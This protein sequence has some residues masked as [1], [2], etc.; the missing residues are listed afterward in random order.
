METVFVGAVAFGA[1][2]GATLTL[3]LQDPKPP[4]QPITS[5]SNTISR[6]Q[7]LL[8]IGTIAF[9]CSSIGDAGVTTCA[10]TTSGCRFKLERKNE[11]L[12][13]FGIRLD[14]N[15]KPMCGTQ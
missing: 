8:N 9:S 5:A 2:L 12:F 14:Y 1:I 3:Q 6:T 10:E 13:A 11:G 15:G 7:H 4:K